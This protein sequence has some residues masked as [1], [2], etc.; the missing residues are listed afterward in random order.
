M[1]VIRSAPG[2]VTQEKGGWSFID[3]YL[4]QMM[5]LREA[6]LQDGHYTLMYSAS[7]LISLRVELLKVYK[8]LPFHQISGAGGYHPML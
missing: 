8:T 1:V 6:L 3:D 7:D 5:F 2:N 4:V